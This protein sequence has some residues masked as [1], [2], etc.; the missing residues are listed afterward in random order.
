MKTIEILLPEIADLYGEIGTI[1]YLK[2]SFSDDNIIET[3][4]KDRP[5]FLDNK[6]DFVYLGPMSEKWQL[7][8]IDKFMPYK[9]DI[10]RQIEYGLCFLTVSTGFEIFGKYIEDPSGNKIETLGIFDYYTV[11]NFTARYNQKMLLKFD[12]SY[13]IGTKSQFTQ[14]YGIKDEEAFMTCVNGTGNNPESKFDGFRYKNF[15]G[16]HLHAP[17]L[18][19]NPKLTKYMF[20]KINPEIENILYEEIITESHEA[21]LTYNLKA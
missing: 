2:K 4:L 3:K 16:T 20:K 5:Y 19:C 6:V 7:K 14:I 8:V 9:E 17:I 13:V 15:H 21:R 12:D 10:K 1:N 18:L 11:Q